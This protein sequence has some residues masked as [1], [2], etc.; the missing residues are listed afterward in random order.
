MAN[1]S[2]IGTHSTNGVAA[3]H[4]RLLTERMFPE[5]ALVFPDRFNNKTNGITQR[6]W[7]LDSNPLLASKI[8]EAI[9]DGWITDFSTISKLAPFS[10]DSNFRGD[11]LNIKHQAKGTCC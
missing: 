6:R 8:S 9:G 3:L 7:L 2:I 1:L 11:F 10:E 4:S 5:F